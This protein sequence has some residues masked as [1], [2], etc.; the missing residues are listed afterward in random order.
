MNPIEESYPPQR[1]RT[2]VPRNEISTLRYLYLINSC[3]NFTENLC[4]HFY[5]QPVTTCVEVQRKITLPSQTP[6]LDEFNLHFLSVCLL[7]RLG[8]NTWLAL[9]QFRFSVL[10]IHE[11]M[12]VSRFISTCISNHRENSHQLSKSDVPTPSNTRRRPEFDLTCWFLSQ[13]YPAT[14][15]T[16]STDFY[17]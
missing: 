6:I 16:S 8:W 7:S 14:L 2:I 15:F 3:S 13:R 11:C 17:E 4:L 5:R 12:T 10:V 1:H 9:I